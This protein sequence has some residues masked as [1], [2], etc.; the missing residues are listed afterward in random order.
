M[1]SVRYILFILFFENNSILD[2]MSSVVKLMMNCFFTT[3]H[4]YHR[5]RN[6]RNYFSFVKYYFVILHNKN[7]FNKINIQTVFDE[8]W[9]IIE[10]F[11]VNIFSFLVVF[12]WEKYKMR[13]IF[14]NRLLTVNNHR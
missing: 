6:S 10:Y 14:I 8:M 3:I 2:F 4:R 13:I 7:I 1:L 5:I 12:N 11:I 9:Y